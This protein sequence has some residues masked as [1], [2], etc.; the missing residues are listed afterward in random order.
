MRRVAWWSAARRVRLARG[1]GSRAVNH[2]RASKET[3]AMVN[4]RLGG[5]R[6]RWLALLVVACAVAAAALA[7]TSGASR[8]A[9]P[10]IP[11]VTVRL[12]W[13]PAANLTIQT[14]PVQ[15]GWFKDVGIDL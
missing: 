3:G 13:F 10:T 15:K 14:I 5:P 4:V 12:A 2:A 11:Q 1:E 6:R 7:G 8:S 9:A